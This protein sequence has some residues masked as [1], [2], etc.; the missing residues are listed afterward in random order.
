MMDAMGVNQHHDAVTGTAKQAVSDNYAELIG[1]AMKT[2]NDQYKK[3]I[4]DST[5]KTTGVD[6]SE[7]SMCA[8]TNGTYVDCPI[9]EHFYGTFLL[10]SFNPS[11]VE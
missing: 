11:T 2:S 5:K 8:K 9:D 10:T 4:G 7:W 6:A 1:S 3:L